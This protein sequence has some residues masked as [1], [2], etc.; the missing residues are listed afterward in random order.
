MTR[1][2]TERGTIV[3]AQGGTGMSRLSET[4]RIGGLE[5]AALS[6]GAPDRALG[7]FFFEVDPAEWTRAIG[8]ASP[9]E[10]VPFNFGTFLIRGEGRT[11]LV[12]AGYG[13]AGKGMNIPG[14]GE[15]PQRLAELGVKPEEIDTLVHTHLHLDHC[16][17]DTDA[18]N[19]RRATF[20][21]ATVYV[22]RTELEF[23][24]GPATDEN[25]A[26][27]PARAA[28]GPL[29]DAGRV[30]PFDGEFAVTGSLT[31]VPTPGHTPGHCSVLL[32]S[33]GEHLLIT[34]D[35]AHH[36]VHL[37]RHNWI[38]Q[39][40]WDKAESARSRAKLA[41][42]AADR[43][44]VVTSGHFPILTLGRVRRVEGGYRW[45]KL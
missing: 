38:P 19:G 25:P 36:P 29:V 10:P 8:I 34:G 15:L 23:W 21:N 43:N 27:R 39:V 5:I 30:Q 18:E 7:G 12:D 24:T 17:W 28:I 31:M 13:S 2:R 6:D 3:G 37:E 1:D 22:S 44:A 42:L 14:G 9:D 33:Q 20:P 32:V 40:D 16:G 26:A 35:A 41:Q 4:F 45:E 11:V